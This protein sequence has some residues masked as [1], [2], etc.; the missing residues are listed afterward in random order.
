MNS[1]LIK[2]VPQSI[3]IYDST[4][5]ITIKSSLVIL[6]VE[7]ELKRG[8]GVRVIMEEPYSIAKLYLKS[9]NIT[10]EPYLTIKLADRHFV[11]F[12]EKSRT[13]TLFFDGD[14]I[15]QL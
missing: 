3:T 9:S 14:T 6:K 11:G 12:G 13:A 10:D 5:E 2:I 1:N 7:S 8:I 4:K 15:L